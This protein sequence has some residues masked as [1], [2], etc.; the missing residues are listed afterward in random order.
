MIDLSIFEGASIA[1]LGLGRTGL[2]AATAL[3]KAGAQVVVWD[4]KPEARTAASALGIAVGDLV[5]LPWAEYAFLLVSP[6]I[7]IHVKHPHS[8]IRA[9]EISGVS[10]ISDLDLFGIAEGAHAIIGITGTNGKSTTSALIHHILR[11]GKYATQLGGNFGTAALALDP[12][13]EEGVYVLELSSYQLAGTSQLPVDVAVLLNM[14]PDHLAYHQTFENYVDAKKRIFELNRMQPNALPQGVAIG[15]DDP[16]CADIAA[17]LRQEGKH[18]VITISGHRKEADVTAID[19]MLIDQ[20]DGTP[21][22]LLPLHEMP[23]L[24][25]A[26]NIQNAAAA[27]AALK[28]QG[29]PLDIIRTGLRTFAGLTHRQELV[30]DRAGI[31]IINDSKA[32]NFASCIPA[33]DTFSNSVWIVGG[34]L[35]AGDKTPEISMELLN[36][37]QNVL[38]VV[39][40][41]PDAPFMESLLRSHIPVATTPT[42]KD[43][44]YKAIEIATSRPERPVH[45]LFSPGSASLDTFRDFE[46]RGTVF[47]E[48]VMPWLEGDKI[49]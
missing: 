15:I 31:R 36:H 43:A 4:D 20:S 45:I 49:P 18:R 2:A 9:A 48:L 38:E 21:L 11:Q 7:P 35:K 42:L 14:S 33:L 25:G 39:T 34:T 41:G 12:L 26:H 3:Q 28:L 19:G 29:V 37:L 1:I 13:P 32:T 44:T 22:P 46:E 30:G 10:C 24:K 8:A 5:P 23:H 47:K 40:Y 6:G 27:Y 17:T 16:I